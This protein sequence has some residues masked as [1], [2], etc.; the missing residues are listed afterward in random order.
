MEYRGKQLLIGCDALANQ[1]TMEPGFCQLNIGVGSSAVI[2]YL[3]SPCIGSLCAG[4]IDIIRPFKGGRNQ[5]YFAIH[6]AQHTANTGSCTTLTAEF[7]NGAAHAQGGNKVNVPCQNG[8]IA[9][10][11]TDNQLFGLTVEN[12]SVRS[13][14]FQGEAAH[15][16]IT[17]LNFS[18]TSSMEPANRK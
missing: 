5:R 15:L 16:L 4:N 13:N 10:G 1:R 2:E 11:G 3:I 14:D 6:Y 7:H 17:P 12:Q 8:H 9:G 18:T